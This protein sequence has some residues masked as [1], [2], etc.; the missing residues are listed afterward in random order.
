MQSKFFY[1]Y[2]IYLFLA[3][4]GLCCCMWAFSGGSKGG[5]LFIAVCSLLIAVASRCGARALGTAELGLQAPGLQQLWLAG[6]VAPRHVGS[7]PTRARTCVPCIGRRILNH[8]ATRE[9]P[10]QLL[11]NCSLYLN[12]PHPAPP[13]TM[14][15]L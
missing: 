12:I 11:L 3:A 13:R 10:T 5:L 8:C 4:L 1:L 2:F 15:P 9:V 7:S 14:V 6:L